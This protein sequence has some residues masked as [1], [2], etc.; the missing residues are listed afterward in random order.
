MD[1]FVVIPEEAEAYF[2]KAMRTGYVVGS[3]TLNNFPFPG[4]KTVRH[5]DGSF[6]LT[7]TWIS[8]PYSNR[9]SGVT[10]IYYKDV[11]IWVMHYGGW[12]EK[13]ADY[14]LRAALKWSY[15]QGEFTGGRGPEEFETSYMRY[16][17]V[18]A[19]N[20]FVNFEG[21]EKIVGKGTG[22]LYGTH[23]YRGEWQL[24]ES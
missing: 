24:K 6:S 20:R 12:Y 16:T 15:E 9:S 17:N 5:K 2:F 1:K 7:D 14:V 21:I 8:T 11:P 4:W 13:E 10:T 22:T 3:K 19:R 18:L 23:W